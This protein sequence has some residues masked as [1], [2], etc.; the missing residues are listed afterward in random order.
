VLKR[1]LSSPDSEF[2][3]T[4]DGTALALLSSEMAFVMVSLGA[5][6]QLLI[7]TPCSPLSVVK[8]VYSTKV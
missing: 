7:W 1:I 5:P 3:L 6:R 8:G 4:T 2:H